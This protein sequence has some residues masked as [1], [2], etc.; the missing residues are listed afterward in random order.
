MHCRINVAL[1]NG[2]CRHIVG[3]TAGCCGRTFA[4]LNRTIMPNAKKDKTK[5]YEARTKMLEKLID[6]IYENQESDTNFKQSNNIK[7]STL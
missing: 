1:K 4:S 7:T 3:L 5:K 6:Q 2:K